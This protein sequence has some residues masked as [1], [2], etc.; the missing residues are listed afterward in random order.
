MQSILV[1][2]PSETSRACHAAGA[3]QT[4]EAHHSL[5]HRKGTLTCAQ[6]GLRGVCSAETLPGQWHTALSWPPFQHTAV[7]EKQGTSLNLLPPPWFSNK[8]QHIHQ[9]PTHCPMYHCGTPEVLKHFCSSQPAH[10][11]QRGL[12][13]SSLPSHPQLLLQ[14][15]REGGGAANSACVVAPHPR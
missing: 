11:Q 6:Q 8:T 12:P 1:S 14:P 13:R 10:T 4:R 15:H 2:N 9:V 7:R 5:T 3:Q